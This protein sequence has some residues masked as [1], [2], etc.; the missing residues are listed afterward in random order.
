MHNPKPSQGEGV[1]DGGVYSP[2]RKALRG[3]MSPS[4]PARRQGQTLLVP[5]SQ[6][7]MTKMNCPR[8]TMS[9]A[10]ASMT[11]TMRRANQGTLRPESTVPEGR[12]GHI[13][14]DLATAGDASL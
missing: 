7:T 1:G 12:L 4:S 5:G 9:K 2:V 14:V 3:R 8:G 13:P 10:M 11:M 6:D